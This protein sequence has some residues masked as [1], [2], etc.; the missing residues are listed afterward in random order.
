MTGAK[1]AAQGALEE[2]PSL[3]WSGQKGPFSRTWSWRVRIVWVEGEKI[4]FKVE[5][6]TPVKSLK[7]ESNRWYDQ[8]GRCWWAG[9]EDE[10]KEVGRCQFMKY[11]GYQAMEFE[12]NHK[13]LG[14]PWKISTSGVRKSDSSL[15]EIILDATW[16]RDGRNSRK[17]AQGPIGKFVSRPAWLCK[18]WW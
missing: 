16:R 17:E 6:I 5:R 4:R 15:A 2:R 10:P 3:S 1:R 14:S 11:L 12:S 8:S 9:M 13:A 7:T 18:Q